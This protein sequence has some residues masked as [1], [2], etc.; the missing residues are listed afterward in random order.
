[1]S[2]MFEFVHCTWNPI[3]GCLH[4]CVYCWAR[5]LAETKLANTPRY[6][7]G[8]RHCQFLLSEMHPKFQTNNSIVFMSDMGDWL[9]DWVKRQWQEE[10]IEVLKKNDCVRFLSCTKNPKIYSKI[11]L[12]ENVIRGCTIE[13]NRKIPEWISKAPQPQERIHHM[14][15]NQWENPSF[16][17]VEPVLDFDL[18]EFTREL[19]ELHPDFGVAVGYDNYNNGLPEPSLDKVLRLTHNLE[20]EGLTVYRKTLR[21]KISVLTQ[22]TKP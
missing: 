21:E 5:K 14:W 9:G 12:P 4:D 19:V 22:E 10:V 11:S 3:V 2:K 17:V 13:T 15:L 16:I 6:K 8:F 7:D 1:M 18:D 20:S